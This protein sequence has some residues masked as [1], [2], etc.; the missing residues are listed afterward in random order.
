MLNDE[1]FQRG[2]DGLQELIKLLLVVKCRLRLKD[3]ILYQLLGRLWQ[4]HI[5]HGGISSVNLLLEHR[6]LV[7]HLRY[8]DGKV[9]E[10]VSVNNGANQNS[11][12]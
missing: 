11:V 10:N 8:E 9:T 6:L 5:L 12:S 4:L 2:R 1:Q 7:V 3:V